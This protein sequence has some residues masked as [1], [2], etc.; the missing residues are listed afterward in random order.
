MRNHRFCISG[1]INVVRSTTPGLMSTIGLV[2]YG[3]VTKKPILRK[4]RENQNTA[5]VTFGRGYFAFIFISHLTSDNT[6]DNVLM[7]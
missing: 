5:T 3:M 4:E 6:L 2:N 1:Y 7:Y